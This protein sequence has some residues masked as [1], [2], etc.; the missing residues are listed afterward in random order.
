MVVLVGGLRR[1]CRHPCLVLSALAAC[2]LL[3]VVV[4]RL[5]GYRCWVL[6]H[7]QRAATEDSSTTLGPA[8]RTVP[9]HGVVAVNRNNSAATVTGL[10]DIF[11]SVKTT[12]KYHDTRIGLL[13]RT[14][15]SLAQKQVR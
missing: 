11:I 5:Y 7:G 2:C 6:S 14:W 12:G 4:L 13:L 15:L 1:I 9:P 10:D 3:L 8:S